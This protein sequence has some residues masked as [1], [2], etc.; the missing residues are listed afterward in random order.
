MA[1]LPPQA[2]SGLTGRLPLPM[3]RPLEARGAHGDQGPAQA[4]LE[5]G[6]G[7]AAGRAPSTGSRVSPGAARAGPAF[8]DNLKSLSRRSESPQQDRTLAALR[9]PAAA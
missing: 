4:A 6:R 5:D 3:L 7:T 2:A 1:S 8:Y 9:G